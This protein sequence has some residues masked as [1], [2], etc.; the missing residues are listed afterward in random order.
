[1]LVVGIK[2]GHDGSLAAIRDGELV[3]S[4]EAEKDSFRRYGSVTPSTLLEFAEHLDGVPDAVGLGGWD[5]PNLLRHR[6][7][8]AGYLGIEEGV[9]VPGRFFGK[10]VTRF[11]STHERSHVMMALGMAPRTAATAQA[12]LVWE[13]VIGGFY[14]IDERFRLVKKIPVMD[15][16]GIRYAYL[17]DLANPQ[18]HHHRDIPHPENA[19][20][21]MALA[22]YGRAEDA[23]SAIVSTVDRI[24]TNA[25]W[26]PRTKPGMAD[27][28]V[29]NAGLRSPE[30]ATAAALLTRRIFQA[31]AEAATSLLPAGLP[32]RISGGCGLNCE[33]NRGWRELGHFS[34]VFVPPCTN[35]SGSAIG[36]AIDVQTTLTGDPY[37]EWDVYRGLP[38]SHDAVPDPSRWRRRPLDLDALAR[39]LQAGRVVAWVQGRTEIGPR[40]LGNRSLLAEPFS[41]ATRDR[42][43]DIKQRE[44]Y[45]P[46]APVCRLE[47]AAKVFDDA[48][49]DPHMLYFRRVTEPALAAV[50]HVDG[51]ARAQ[52]VTRDGNPRLHD[53]LSAFAGLTGLGVLCNTSLNFKGY[54]FINRVSDLVRYCED[55]GVRDMVVGDDWYQWH[56]DMP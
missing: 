2:P 39:A 49:P 25:A 44:D 52:T 41:A 17:Y 12:V 20:K 53:L 34:D 9:S 36:T 37:I 30:L 24:L 18:L 13:G 33:W 7:I 32:L 23:D 10:P 35:D 56:E 19:G 50:T 4:L 16:P 14:L 1:M 54:G 5:A 31:Y 55:R 45:R 42:L 8:G 15:H 40:A 48:S 28:P 46:I 6:P 3:L 27:S 22:A 29:F 38:P 51:T 43:N 47:D 21:L 26:G 11:T